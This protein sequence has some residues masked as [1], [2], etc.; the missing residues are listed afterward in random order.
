MDDAHTPGCTKDLL[1]PLTANLTEIRASLD[2]GLV[3][4][5][6]LV[7]LYT[8]QIEK[9]NGYLR[10]V[11]MLAPKSQLHEH[12]EARDQERARGFLRGPLHGIPVLLKVRR[13]E[14]YLGIRL[15]SLM[16]VMS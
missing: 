14:K 13:I 6:D 12:A 8:A 4:S 11:A 2:A 1:D 7:D 3:R 15:K 10:A 16:H 9:Y 5:T